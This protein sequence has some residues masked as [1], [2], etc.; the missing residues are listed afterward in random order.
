MENVVEASSTTFE[1]G[2]ALPIQVR[3]KIINGFLIRVHHFTWLLTWNGFVLTN[4]VSIVL[5]I[6]KTMMSAMSLE[7]G[8]CWLG[9]SMDVFVQF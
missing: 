1:D 5:F 4:I 6:W 3:L 8:M 2:D 9:C 7:W